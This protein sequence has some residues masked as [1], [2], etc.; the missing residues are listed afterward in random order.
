MTGFSVK[1]KAFSGLSIY[2]GST[3]AAAAANGTGEWQLAEHWPLLVLICGGMMSLFVGGQNLI[4]LYESFLAKVDAR[5]VGAVSKAL[6]EH[7][8]Q[9]EARFDAILKSQRATKDQ[10]SILLQVMRAN[11][12]QGHGLTPAVLPSFNSKTDSNPGMDSTG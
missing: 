6:S 10:I 4:R 5:V 9:E 12:Q 3:L 11:S 1:T 8:K 2:A 7:T